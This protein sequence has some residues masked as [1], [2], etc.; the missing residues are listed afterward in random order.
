MA[1]DKKYYD[2]MLRKGFAMS[3]MYTSENSSD[4]DDNENKLSIDLQ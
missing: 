3:N 4:F 2:R 1:V